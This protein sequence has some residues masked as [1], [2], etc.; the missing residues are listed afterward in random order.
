MKKG[1]SLVALVVTIIVL[2]ILAGT[3]ILTGIQG[4]IIDTSKEATFK[5]DVRAFQDELTRK[6]LK[7]QEKFEIT[8]KKDVEKDTALVTFEGIQGYIQSFTEKYTDKLGIYQGEIVYLEGVTEEQ[9]TWLTEIGISKYV[10]EVKYA[11]AEDALADGWEFDG[12]DGVSYIGTETEITAPSKIG[13]VEIK[14]LLKVATQVEKCNISN[15]ITS[16]EKDAFNMCLNLKDVTIPNSLITIG[17]TAFFYCTSLTSIEIPNS[18]TTIGTQAFNGCSLN[19]VKIP[20][21]ITTIEEWV[22]AFSSTIT[23]IE[24]PTS[25]TTIRAGAFAYCEK[26]T[27]VKIPNSVTTIGTQAFQ[28]CTS[29][30]KITIPNSVT[31]IGDYAFQDYNCLTD[32][33]VGSDTLKTRLIELGIDEK[34]ITVDTSINQ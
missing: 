12:V 5:N 7:K 18:V 24:I 30:T 4:G 33:I 13:N 28:N 6:I 22:F 19:S 15:G 17:D 9:K 21:S 14:K 16:I 32:V 25:V 34:I 31:T 23:S 1:I 29:L 3:V 26:L 2:I 8:S 20:N 27:E 11:T 10:P